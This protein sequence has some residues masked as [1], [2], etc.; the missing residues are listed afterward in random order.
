MSS[1]PLAVIYGFV[2]V[3][4]ATTVA[5]GHVSVASAKEGIVVDLFGH[6]W[7]PPNGECV[8][9]SRQSIIDGK[10]TIMCHDEEG[11]LMGYVHLEHANSCAPA[12][13]QIKSDV[14]CVTIEMNTTLLTQQFMQSIDR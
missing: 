14:L 3:S 6:Y 8:L 5:L 12:P 2:V 13:A 1:A 9:L 11:H 4:I 7:T 10:W